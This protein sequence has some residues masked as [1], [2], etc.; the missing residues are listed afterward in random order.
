MTNE[1]EVYAALAAILG[2]VLGQPDVALSPAL[3]LEELPEWESMKLIEV[4]VA[5]EDR[6][7]MAFGTRELDRLRNVGDLARVVLA[8]APA[9]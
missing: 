2:E 5:L 4:V 1:A 3:R 8:K 6:F 7:G 9:N